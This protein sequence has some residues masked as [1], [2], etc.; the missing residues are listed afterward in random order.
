MRRAITGSKLSIS[1]ADVSYA[2]DETEKSKTA[3]KCVHE[4]KDPTAAKTDVDGG[5]DPMT[6]NPNLYDRHLV[7]S[8]V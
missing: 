6:L 4:G 2:P 3:S 5:Q 1:M 7:Y 8:K